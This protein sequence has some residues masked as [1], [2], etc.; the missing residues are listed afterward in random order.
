M[1]TPP[2]VTT[3]PIDPKP[4]VAVTPPVAIKPPVTTLPIPAPIPPVQPPK[5]APEPPKIELPP[6]P[7]APVETV[8]P[9]SLPPEKHAFIGII[10]TGFAPNNPDLDY[11]KV[12]LGRD[13]IDKDSNPLFTAGTGNEH[14]TF[15]WGLVSAIQGNDRGIDGYN[16]KANVYLSRAIGSGEWDLALT[17][18]VSEAKGQKQKN[19]IALLPLDLT[20][21]NADGTITTRYE[22]TNRERA[23]LE[24]ARQNGV[25]LVVAAGNDG[26]VMS[27]LGQSSQEFENIITVGSSDGFGRSDYSSYGYGLDILVPGGAIDNPTLST[28]GDDVGTMSG[29][30][31]SAAKAAGMASKVWEANPDLSVT[32]VIDVLTGSAIDLKEPGWDQ[33]TGF[34]VVNF[35]KA[36]ELAKETAPQAYIPALFSNPTTSGL[37]GQVTPLERATADQFNGK[38]YDWVSYT[39]QSGDTLSQIA[40]DTMGDASADA[41]NFIAQHNGIADAN[42]IIAGETIY[43]PKEVSAPVDPGPGTTDPGP[44]ITDPGPV[45][46]DPGPVIT[47]PG[48]TQP[49][50]SIN[51]NGHTVGGN[52]YPVFQNYQGTLGNPI[53]DV[54]NYNGASYQIF[55]NGSIVSSQYGTFP[56]YG[57]I[58]Q[59]FLKNGGL[60]GWLGEPKSGEKGLGN[61]NIIQYFEDG[62]IY[63]NGSKATAYRYGTTLPKTPTN[64][65]SQ[66]GVTMPNFNLPAYR[67]NNIFWQSGYAPASTHPSSTNL[68]SALGNCT[69]YVNGRLQQLG[70]NTTA[71]NKLSGNAYDWDNQA[72]AAGISMSNTPQVGDIAQWESGHVAVVEKVNPD[73]TILISESSY[74]PNSGSAADYLYKTET[75]AASSPSRFICLPSSDSSGS[76]SSNGSGPNSVVTIGVTPISSGCN[77]S[78]PIDDAGWKQVLDERNTDFNIIKLNPL[79]E[80]G[81]M[82]FETAH[83]AGAA[84]WKIAG[85][86]DA[87]EMLYHYLDEG[88]G[89]ANYS[90]DLNEAIKESSGMRNELSKMVEGSALSKAIKAVQEGCQF[91]GIGNNWDTAGHFS[92][93]DP[94]WIAAVGGFHKRYT[95]DFKLTPNTDEITLR[96][97]FN[98]KDVYDFDG[99][100]YGLTGS[101]QLHL[102]GYARAFEVSGQSGFYEWKYT[103]AGVKLQDGFDGT[104]INAT[105]SSGSSSGYNT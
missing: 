23:A 71:L 3:A 68:G 103:L 21:K 98:L 25:L 56:L 9:I 79:G 54:T 61:G 16:D 51:I 60:E 29:T 64:I 2:P 43:I 83:Y 58:R 32:Q 38:Y 86:D 93:G 50:N 55:E 74:T 46:T 76:S 90:I 84:T 62:Y 22:F 48:P 30:S 45:I 88:N 72:A 20:Q 66:L 91:G 99:Y 5:I 26:G 42:V 52:F 31:A 92:L 73:G 105:E 7:E 87:A 40:L 24:N 8:L 4:P 77:N 63:W 15:N 13:R 67:E 44:V 78:D 47:D 36:V 85:W 28:V 27:V 57:A 80:L 70:Y 35:N 10:D 14:G 17:D 82:E 104:V 59:T 53:S 102:S 94:N 97:Q 11:S 69:W 89:G 37:E 18:F 65:G 41:Y 1:A 12:T 33:E 19:A 101:H 6:T 75:I 39:I 95:G 34:G 49:S 81:R 96:L 100:A